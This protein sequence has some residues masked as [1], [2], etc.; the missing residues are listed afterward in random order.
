MKFHSGDR[1]R[2][3]ERAS[4]RD[5]CIS[6]LFLCAAEKSRFLDLL[7][8]WL[9]A[10]E[11]VRQF[12]LLRS[13]YLDCVTFDCDTYM[14]WISKSY[15][16]ISWKRRN[17]SRRFTVRLWLFFVFCSEAA[18]FVFST[19][20]VLIGA[21]EYLFWLSWESCWLYFACVHQQVKINCEEKVFAASNAE[22]IN[23]ENCKASMHLQK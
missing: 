19:K 8:S 9:A 10:V 6:V 4:E 21:L 23:H 3:R 5:R 22:Y 7:P 20:R 18:F 15:V 1:V 12:G 13:G 14:L 16:Y 17:T 11:G 2:G